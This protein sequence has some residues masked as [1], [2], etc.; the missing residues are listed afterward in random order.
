[1]EEHLFALLVNMVV[2]EIV[3][4]QLENVLHVLQDM[5]LIQIRE[6]VN[7]VLLAIILH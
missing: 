4:K 5:E 6:N 7:N 2:M 1:M 3:S